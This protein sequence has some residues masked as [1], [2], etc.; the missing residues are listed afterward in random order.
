VHSLG[1][2][3][4]AVLIALFFFGLAFLILFEQKVTFGL[5]FQI[6]DLHHETFAIAAVALGLGVLIGSVVTENHKE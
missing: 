6:D 5:W 3:W 4:V 2:R 1:N